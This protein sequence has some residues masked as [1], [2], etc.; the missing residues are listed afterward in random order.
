MDVLKLK[1]S[2]P[3]AYSTWRKFHIAFYCIVDEKRR[4]LNIIRKNEETTL[5]KESDETQE[6]SKLD[7]FLTLLQ[8]EEER[9]AASEGEEY[10]KRTQSKGEDDNIDTYLLNG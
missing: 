3:Y 1:L 10:V 5:D 9:E 4:L 6:S 2:E 8:D 7:R